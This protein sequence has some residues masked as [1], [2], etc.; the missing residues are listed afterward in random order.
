MTEAEHA[1]KLD[2]L[3]RL[4][5]DPDVNLQPVRVWELLAE[6]SRQLPAES[7]AADKLG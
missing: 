6:V 5:N 2:E 7:D 4:I 1:S 3:D